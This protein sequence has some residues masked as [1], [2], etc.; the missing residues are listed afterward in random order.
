MNIWDE[1]IKAGEL[2]KL[3]KEAKADIIPVLKVLLDT[4]TVRMKDV[5]ELCE[6]HGVSVDATLNLLNFLHINGKRIYLGSF[7]NEMDAARAYE[8]ATK[9]YHGHQ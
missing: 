9:K 6:A 4:D 5:I 1:I 3:K 2:Q 8:Q 7:E